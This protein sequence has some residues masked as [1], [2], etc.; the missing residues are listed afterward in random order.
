[1]LRVQGRLQ[2]AGLPYEVTHPILIPKC[3]LGV[4][5]PRHEHLRMKHTGVNVVFTKLRNQYWLIGDRRICKQVK[6]ECVSCQH[7]DAPAGSKTMSHLPAMRV[8]Q[9]PPFSVIGL[10]H[11]GP[12][13]RGDY[14]GNKFYIILFTC[15]VTRA[16]HLE[17]V[18][19]LSCETTV[20]ALRR[21]ITRR[22]IPSI[23]LSD[24]AKGFQ[25]APWW[26]GWWER[27]IGSVKSALKRSIGKR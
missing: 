24:N 1:M 8:T 22:G 26:G 6:T 4:L 15:A 12:L 7:V 5:L 16:I 9:S 2:F 27:L 23:I 17:L 13:Y 18:G 21:V 11:G 20:M 10:D 25:R 14:F 3:N 19:S